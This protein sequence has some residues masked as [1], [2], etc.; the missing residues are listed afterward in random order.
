A[1]VAVS[2]GR[3]H[4][5]YSTNR[6]A[7]SVGPGIVLA[8]ARAARS[9]P[10]ARGHEIAGIRTRIGAA[11]MTYATVDATAS[12]ASCVGVSVERAASTWSMSTIRGRT[13]PNTRTTIPTS[14]AIRATTRPRLGR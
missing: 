12:T 1:A 5:R 6:V 8:T 9:A 7:T 11:F 2:A 13:R 14:S 4:W 3:S 10:T